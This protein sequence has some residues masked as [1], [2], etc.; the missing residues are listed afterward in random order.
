MFVVYNKS[1]GGWHLPKKIAQKLDVD[2]WDDRE[3]TRTNPV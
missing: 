3:G 1:Y 2:V